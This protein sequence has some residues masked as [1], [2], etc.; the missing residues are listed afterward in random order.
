MF[1]ESL[2]KCN[3]N[4][5]SIDGDNIKIICLTYTLF[6]INVRLYSKYPL[7]IYIC[8]FWRT[9]LIEYPIVKI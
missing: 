5:K 8:I 9:L 3:N 2:Y 6:I 1:V 4:G 7:L